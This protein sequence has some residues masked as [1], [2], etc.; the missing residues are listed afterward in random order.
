MLVCV[1]G[2]VQIWLTLGALNLS[3]PGDST[4][5]LVSRADQFLESFT[6]YCLS[7]YFSSLQACCLLVTIS[8]SKPV[9]KTYIKLIHIFSS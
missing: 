4:R 3:V 6:T 7:S 8:P 9:Y 2:L 5:L 1:G